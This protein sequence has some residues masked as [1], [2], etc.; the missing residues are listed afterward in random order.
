MA[1]SLF[2]SRIP[3]SLLLS[4]T[5]SYHSRA[6]AAG[7]GAKMAQVFPTTHRLGEV[8]KEVFGIAHDPEV[9]FNSYVSYF[10]QKKWLPLPKPTLKKH[11]FH[12]WGK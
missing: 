11:V 10:Y 3:P 8:R 6:E 4:L 12:K 5:L 7:L 1:S 9:L 2:W